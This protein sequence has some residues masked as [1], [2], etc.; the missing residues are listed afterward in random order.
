LYKH[1]NPLGLR[2]LPL[3]IFS[4][5]INPLALWVFPLGGGRTPEVSEIL[6]IAGIFSPSRRAE[7]KET[8]QWA[9]LAKE[10]DCRVGSAEQQRGFQIKLKFLFN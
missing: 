6:L 9:V 4:Q 3:G 7:R 10:P 8:A 2:P 5:H 1:V